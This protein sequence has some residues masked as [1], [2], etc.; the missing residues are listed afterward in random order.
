MKTVIIT[1]ASG[2]LGKASVEKFIN[3]G[4]KVI[5]LVSPGKTLGFEVE[6]DVE[7]Y[8]SDLTDEKSVDSV[9]AQVLAKHQTIDAA[10]LLV[11]GYAPGGI[12]ETDGSVLKKMFSLNFDTAYFVSRPIY[13]H[14][15]QQ[16]NGGRIVFVGA[17]PALRAKDANKAL[18]YALSKSLIFKLAEA[19][20]AAASTKNVTASVVVP[21]TIDTPANRKAMPTADFSAWVKAEEIAGALVLLCSADSNAWRDTVLKI[22]GRS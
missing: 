2:N 1:G 11:G 4:Y 8:D 15:M 20:N 12:S 9:I 13:Q 17:R 14:M 22:Y 19:L 6:G 16:A 18:G 3:A 10:I 7:T 21:S 5:A